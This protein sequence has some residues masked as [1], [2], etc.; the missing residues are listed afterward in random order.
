[1]IL[2]DSVKGLLQADGKYRRGRLFLFIIMHRKDLSKQ[3][4]GIRRKPDKLIQKN[5]RTCMSVG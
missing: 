3:Q 2:T 4:G 1:M 5:L